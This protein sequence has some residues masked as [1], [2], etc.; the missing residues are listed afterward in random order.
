[1]RIGDDLALDLNC[2]ACDQ[3]LNLTLGQIRDN[4]TVKCPAGH[5]IDVKGNYDSEIKKVE[6]TLDNFGR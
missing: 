2:P 4:P 3:P 5:E 6:D 1:M